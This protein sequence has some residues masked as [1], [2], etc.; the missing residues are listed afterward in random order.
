MKKT[1][2]SLQAIDEEACDQLDK[3]SQ[4]AIVLADVKL[5]RSYPNHKRYFKFLQIAFDMQ[6]HFTVFESFRKWLQVQAGHHSEIICPDGTI[7]VH[8]DS[9]N[10]ENMEEP[11]FQQMF[12]DAINAYLKEFGHGMSQDQ[13]MQIIQFG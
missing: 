2:Y 4:D 12:S 13:F 7:I 11:E 9:I 5:S 1:G 3:I 6:E 10:F 8:A